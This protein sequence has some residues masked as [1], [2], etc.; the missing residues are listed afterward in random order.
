MPGVIVFHAPTSY[1]N[2]N[3]IGEKRGAFEHP[4]GKPMKIFGETPGPIILHVA[5]YIP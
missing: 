2:C 3:E 1:T 4:L 5:A